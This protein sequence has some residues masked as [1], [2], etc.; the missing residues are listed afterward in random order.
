M[1]IE[2]LDLRVLLCERAE[3]AREVVA[4]TV[5]VAATGRDS[6]ALGG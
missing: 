4:A 3:E 5:V 1:G 6:V 2:P